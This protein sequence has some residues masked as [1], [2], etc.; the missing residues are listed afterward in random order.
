MVVTTRILVEEFLDGDFPLHS[1][2]I[3]GEVVMTDPS[4][5][6]QIVLARIL[7]L[8]TTWIE[9]SPERGLA[10]LGGNW[11]F[12][13][14]TSLSPDGWWV[15][16]DQA[17]TL[18]SNRSDLPPAI[19]FEVRSPSTW[20]RDVGVKLG[21][22]LTGG[23]QEVW[24]VDMAARTITVCRRSSAT[25]TEF[26]DTFELGEGSLT[27]PL[28]DAFSLDVQALFAVLKSDR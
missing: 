12:G 23:V 15:N 21:I 5:Q 27:S 7:F 24:L 6:H 18:T 28:L 13:P 22:Y 26:D 10:G 25:A 20:I 2:L 1:Q 8:L 16:T 9:E 4:F 11:I 19:A 17:A 3:N 14:A